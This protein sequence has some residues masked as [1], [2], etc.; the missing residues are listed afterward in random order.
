MFRKISFNNTNSSNRESIN[1]ELRIG[2]QSRNLNVVLKIESIIFIARIKYN[3]YI[4]VIIAVIIDR[5]LNQ[6][7]TYEYVYYF[8]HRIFPAI[9]VNIA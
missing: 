6:H 4:N 7:F 2:V 1:I 3:Y 5:H 9:A 8:E